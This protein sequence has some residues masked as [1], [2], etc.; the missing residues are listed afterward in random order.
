MTFGDSG[1][2]VEMTPLRKF[3][4]TF[5]PTGAHSIEPRNLQLH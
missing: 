4:I 3:N 5:M 1:V 2:K